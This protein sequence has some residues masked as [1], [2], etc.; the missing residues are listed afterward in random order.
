MFGTVGA[1][2]QTPL[3]RGLALWF[4]APGSYT[5]EDVVEFQIHG[6]PY[7]LDRLLGDILDTG[8]ARLAEPGEFT[9]RAFLNGKLDLTDA[10]RV[11]LM[12]DAETAFEA[13]VA[14]S[15]GGPLRQL[16][17]RLRMQ[18]VRAIASLEAVIEYPEEAET[19]A[20]AGQSLSVLAETGNTLD[21]LTTGYERYGRWVGGVRVALVGVPNAGKSSLLNRMVGY[22]RAIVTE[23]PGTTT[24]TVDVTVDLQGLKISLVDTAGLRKADGEIEQAGLRRTADECNR[25]DL[26]VGVLDPTIPFP[27]QRELLKVVDQEKLLQIVNK[28]DLTRDSF[29]TEMPCVSALTGE[30]VEDL[31]IRIRQ[32]FRMENQGEACLFTVRQ[33]RAVKEARERLQQGEAALQAGAFDLATAELTSALWHLDSLIGRVSTDEILD[34]VFGEFCLGK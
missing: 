33:F 16:M 4:P 7:V 26:V 15:S 32:R 1:D 23:L 19:E 10:E 21:G 29:H 3:D 18:L 2:P 34:S 20:A 9:R 11:H 27:D 13:Q 5:G 17:D 6:S 14:S 24:D 28:S 22:D 30:G 8:Q 12:V 31:L 25:A